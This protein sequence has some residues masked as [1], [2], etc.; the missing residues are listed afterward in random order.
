MLAEW[1]TALWL[2]IKALFRRRRLERDLDD[3]LQFHLA[4]REQKLAEDGVPAEEAHYTARREFG[5]PTKAKETNREMWT[6]AFLETLWQD[7]RYGLRQLR[8]N[9]GFTAVAIITLALGI[10]ANTAIFSVENGVL[11]APLPYAQPDRLVVIWEREVRR[12]ADAW[13]S[14]PNFRDW[15]RDARSFQR[16]VAWIGRGYDLT[17]PGVPEYIDG[18]DVSSGFFATLGVK[19]ALGREFIEREDQA[20]GAPVVIIGSHLWQSRFGSSRHVLGKAVR[21][22]GIDYTVVGVLPPTFHLW[23]HAEVYTPISQDDSPN[24]TG[25]GMHAGVLSIAR[26]KP[27]VSI[28]KAQAEMSTIQEHL[29]QVYPNSD[30]GLGVDVVP[31]KQQIVGKIGGTLLLLMGAIGLVLLIA[32]ANVTNLLLARST[33]RTR[34]FA[35]R[36][37]LGAGRA[38]V[39]RQLLTESVLLSLAGGGLGLLVAAWGVKPVLAAVQANLPR[40]SNIHLD[41]P[42]LL[43]VFGVAVAVGVLFGLA[44]SLK[45][46]NPN[47]QEGLKEGGR[48]SSGN[49]TRA[50]STLVIFQMALTL[51]LLVGAGLLF[52]T[53]GRM[54]QTAPGFNTRNLITFRLGLSPTLTKSPSSTRIAYR[55]LLGRVRGIPGVAAADFTT[56]V[57][58]NDQTDTIPF[59]IDSH[60][61]AALQ[62]APRTLWFLTGPDYLRTMQIP[63]LQGRFFTPEDTINTPCVVAIDTV[64]ARTYFPGE[65]P[66]GHTVSV[67]FDQKDIFGPCRIVGV[68]GHVR[69][70]GLGKPGTDR[71]QSYYA[72][73][74]DPDK[75]VPVNF[76][77]IT[78]ILHTSFDTAAVMPAIRRAVYGAGRNA[79]VYDVRSMQDII[80]ESMS[81]QRF[82][83]IL[84][85]AFAALALLLAFVGIYGV[86]SYSVAQHVHEIGIR[87]ALGAEKQD[88]FRLVIGHGLRLALAGLVIGAAAALVLARLISSFSNLLY[89]VGTG[90]PATFVSV[91]LV[92]TGVAFLACYIPARRATKVDPI[93]ALRHE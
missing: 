64:F 57:P 36:A 60:K 89:G 19:L 70:W 8:H 45:T 1:I 4:M 2:R 88:V 71:V 25:R 12:Q 5:N 15:R 77:G 53:I 83:M 37:A 65:N 6:F 47:L 86:I 54:W 27:G 30:R 75:W 63:L 93:V 69:D 33:A 23:S 7:I 62:S 10:G 84:M 72:L 51:V 42:V 61:P 44:P 18:G 41:V 79:A 82:P 16:M 11:L 13:D 26:L 34:E 78:L 21:L 73:S 52:R 24:L 22:D 35:V 55:Q 56:S 29:D 14:Y 32:C 31:L 9:P 58:L 76:S 80:S 68:V 40:S 81:S 3:E 87:M 48:T 49:Q 50:Q 91:S 67:G 92:L 74:Q 28:A 17:S 38:R 85:G 20:G 39:V 66:V 59:W 43:F 90:D 46:S